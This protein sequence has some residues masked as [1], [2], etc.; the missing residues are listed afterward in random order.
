[1][2][3]EKGKTTGPDYIVTWDLSHIQ[4]LPYAVATSEIQKVFFVMAQNSHPLQKPH[5]FMSFNH[6]RGL[7]KLQH[8]V[9]MQCV[10]GSGWA[11]LP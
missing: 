5:S 7:Y 4:S 8:C 9:N 10:G 6:N 1:M 11:G 2:R 3:K